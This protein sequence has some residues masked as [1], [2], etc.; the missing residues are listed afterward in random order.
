ME[1]VRRGGGM[2][3]RRLRGSC[4]VIDGSLMMAGRI[5]RGGLREGRP[6][7]DR[8]LILGESR[9]TGP[10]TLLIVLMG[11]G[12]AKRASRSRLMVFLL[13]TSG[14]FPVAD[15]TAEFSCFVSLQFR[16]CLHDVRPT[17]VA[18]SNRCG[19]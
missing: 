7:A 15:F 9:A 14:S 12:T 3:R 19:V 2:D 16:W 17:I 10:S 8:S 1:G 11:V 5:A 6:I 4:G 13:V 18:L